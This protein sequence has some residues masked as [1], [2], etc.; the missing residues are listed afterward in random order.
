ML[1]IILLS[2]LL[3]TTGVALLPEAAASCEPGTDPDF[4][5]GGIG[6]FLIRSAADRSDGI[7]CAAVGC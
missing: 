2:A 3:L 4:C 7:L 5:P 6:P 1:R